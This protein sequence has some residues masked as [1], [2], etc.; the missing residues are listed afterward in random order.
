MSTVGDV[1]QFFRALLG[2]RLLAPAQ[3]TEMRRTV[4][5][6]PWQELWRG[7]G[8]GLGLMTRQLP[9]GDWVW[10]HGGGDL[11]MTSDNAVTADGRRSVAVLISGEP[12]DEQAALRQLQASTTLIDHALCASG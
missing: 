12:K 6:L 3:L 10:F 1:N 11:G 2:G 8:Y 9:C 5:A 4:P 7:A